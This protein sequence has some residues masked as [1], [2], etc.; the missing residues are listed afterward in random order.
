MFYAP[1]SIFVQRPR[2]RP[3]SLR[4]A[5]LCGWAPDEAL[6][7]HRHQSPPCV[8]RSPRA[9]CAGGR[10]T[11]AMGVPSRPEVHFSLLPGIPAGNWVIAAPAGGRTRF[12]PIPPNP[13]AVQKSVDG[14]GFKRIAL[15]VTRVLK[16][17]RWTAASLLR[18]QVDSDLRIVPLPFTLRGESQRA[19]KAK[20][21]LGGAG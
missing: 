10:A 11:A 1:P 17:K 4:P 14:T 12:V 6:S 21:R 19:W 2:A 8:C 20:A 7:W 15:M 13:L 16:L 9:W 3:S 5:P 18:S